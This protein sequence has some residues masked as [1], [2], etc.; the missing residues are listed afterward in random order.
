MKPKEII[1]ALKRLGFSERRQTGS[2]VILRHPISKWITCVPMHNK[3]LKREMLFMIL[4]QSHV[5][6]EQLRGA[7]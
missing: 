2:H 5:S 1:R 4:K 6:E 3:D 7:L